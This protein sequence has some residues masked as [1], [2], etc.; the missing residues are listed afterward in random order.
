[1]AGG[2]KPYGKKDG[3]YDASKKKT[4][5]KK[6]KEVED[7]EYDDGIPDGNEAEGVPEAAKHN[8]ET[9]GEKGSR[10]DE[11]GAKDY[12]SL[13]LKADSKS[14]PLWVAP[15][16]HIF[17]EAFSPGKFIFHMLSLLTLI[18]LLS[19]LLLLFSVQTCP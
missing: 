11:Y 19:K 7:D 15:N 9:E 16:G 18:S 14:R 1:M 2:R 12:R 4:F 6:R 10:E 8:I 3:G 5:G 13:K 17:L